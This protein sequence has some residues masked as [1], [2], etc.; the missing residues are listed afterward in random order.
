MSI[1]FQVECPNKGSEIHRNT[2]QGWTEIVDEAVILEKL[3]EENIICDVCKSNF[4]LNDG[5]KTAF[6]STNSFVL[7]SFMHNFRQMGSEDLSPGLVHTIEFDFLFD[8]KPKVF[9]TPINK[10]IRVATSWISKSEF[11]IIS[12]IKEDQDRDEKF[13]VNWYAI[14]NMRGRDLPIWRN[15]LNNSFENRISRNYGYEV[16]DLFTAVEIFFK[17]YFYDGL[18]KKGWNEETIYLVQDL[19][20]GKQ[21]DIY[22]TEIKGNKFSTLYPTLY[23]GYC[24][25]FRKLRNDFVHRGKII[26]NEDAQKCREI[27]FDV[28][29]KTEPLNIF[30]FSN[31]VIM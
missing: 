31:E 15:I 13:Q 19:Q 8:S 16:N 14:G 26:S 3:Y 22:F 18:L 17:N 5:V 9:L 29:I 30:E 12:S 21:L 7:H 20:F 27:A 1:Y 6:S 2:K 11:G 25:I 28:L 10:P 4:S 24:N 23:H